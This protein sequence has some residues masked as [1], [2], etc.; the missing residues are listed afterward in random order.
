MKF[1]EI[2][3]QWW[4]GYVIGL[5]EITVFRRSELI[6][7]HIAPYFDGMDITEI[8]DVDI[9]LYIQAELDHGNRLNHG[10]LCPNT[11]NKSL[12]IINA[13]FQYAQAKNYIIKNPMDLIKKL[14]RVPG[15]EISIFHPDEIALL[16]EV[17]RPKWLGDMILLAY[18][19]GM[20]KEEIYGLQ[21][22]DICFETGI[23]TV[24]Q[25]IVASSPRDYYIN[26][27]KTKTSRRSLMLDKQTKEMLLKKREKATSEWVFENQYGREINPWY[28]VKYFRKA[29]EKANIPIRRFHDLR[30]THI[31]ELV[32]AGIPLPVVQMRA[33]HSDIK[34]TMKYTHVGLNMQES[35]VAYLE[36]R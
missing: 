19:T 32:N 12:D 18:N 3:E 36:N 7:C 4:L 13:I 10:P 1:K 8:T 20:R 29:C 15:R 31:T 23:L 24:N 30:H 11:I 21:W 28:N 26:G 5:R 27:P 2:R 34:M 17:A 16:V 6:R 35:V 14:K 9:N 33:G 25:T 22:K